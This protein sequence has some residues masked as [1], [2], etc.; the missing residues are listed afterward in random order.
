MRKTLTGAEWTEKG[1][2]KI[3]VGTFNNFL[4]LCVQLWKKSIDFEIW[5]SNSQF[6][7]F[8]I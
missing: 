6:R 8:I 7:S 2:C 3:S 1:N 5:D 4:K